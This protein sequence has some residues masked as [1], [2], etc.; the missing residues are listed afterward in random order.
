MSA[1]HRNLQV[2][3]QCKAVKGLVEE[4]KATYW[5][6][7]WM[8]TT[9]YYMIGTWAASARW[10]DLTLALCSRAMR[11]VSKLCRQVQWPSMAAARWNFP[12]D[13]TESLLLIW[14]KGEV[15]W[16]RATQR[17]NGRG[18]DRSLVSSALL[19]HVGRFS[20]QDC[21][22]L[23]EMIGCCIGLLLLQRTGCKTVNEG[24]FS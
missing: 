6:E 5:T 4:K 13:L 19:S 24:K 17:A 3:C 10:M 8:N 14:W 20:W 21:C 2:P 23:P 1:V 11:S 12:G 16:R 9:V 18:S 15:A 7:D 22:P